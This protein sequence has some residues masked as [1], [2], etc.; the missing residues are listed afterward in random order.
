VSTSG[1]M[2]S[3]CWVM[4]VTQNTCE[5]GVYVHSWHWLCHMWPLL[6]TTLRCHGWSHWSGSPGKLGPAPAAASVELLEDSTSTQ[7]IKSWH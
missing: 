7:P 6:V 3:R 4:L 5:G 2:V 1:G